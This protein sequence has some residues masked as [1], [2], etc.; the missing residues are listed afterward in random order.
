M[1]TFLIVAIVL[2]S[3][4]V[5]GATATSAATRAARNPVTPADWKV[6]KTKAAEL[7]RLN[8]DQI[9]PQ[10]V[11]CAKLKR[12]GSIGV[13]EAKPLQQQA[14][15]IATYVSAISTIAVRTHPGQCRIAMVRYEFALQ[16]AVSSAIVSNKELIL[17]NK[18]LWKSSLALEKQ[19]KDSLG[20][21]RAAAARLCK[22]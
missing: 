13:C 18:T 17:A 3:S 21:N 10:F 4:L 8:H 2:V 11:K 15:G 14:R 5:G 1:R 9:S 16:A 20:V 7:G 22:P 12:A 6:W 19:V